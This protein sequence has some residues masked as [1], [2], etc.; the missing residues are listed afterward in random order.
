VKK[1][2]KQLLVAVNQWVQI[3]RYCENDVEVWGINHFCTSF[4]HPDFLLY[5]LA[6]G[7][8]PVTA[9]IVAQFRMAAVSALGKV[10]AQTPGLAV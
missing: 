9:G 2:V 8:V 6:V 3:M 7:T 1:A 5:G 10:D 4:I